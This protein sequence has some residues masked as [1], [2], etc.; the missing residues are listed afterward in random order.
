MKKFIYSKYTKFIAAVLLVVSITLCVLSG[1]NG[2]IDCS[3][4]KEFIYNFESDFKE[5]QHFSNL[6][7]ATEEAV[8]YPCYNYDWNEFVGNEIAEQDFEIIVQ[9]VEKQLNNLYC[10]D[11]I[12][13]YVKLNDTVF[14]NCGATSENDIVTARIYRLTR[15]NADGVTEVESSLRHDQIIRGFPIQ[16]SITSMVICTSIK[17]A[18]VDECKVIWYRQSAMINKIF[19]SVLI[20]AVVAILLFIYLI[21]VCGKTKDG[22]L[23]SVWIDNIWSEIHLAFIVGIGG[24]SVAGCVILIDNLFRGYFSYNFMKIVI[25]SLVAIVSAI[26]LTSL[27]SVVRKIKSKRFI[28]TSIN[29]RL[30]KRFFKM[31]FNFVK[32]ST[33]TSFIIV[34][35]LLI[36]T[37]LIGVLA[38]GT[39][40]SPIWFIV[41][42]LLFGLASFAVAYRTKDIEEIKKG[43]REVRKGNLSY[44][45]PEVKSSDMKELAGNIND[46]A[47]G[48]DE[49]VSAKLKA[50]RLKTELIT[51]VSHDLKTPITS[52]ISYTELLAKIE[53][54]PEEARDYVSVISKKSER[55]KNLTQD[56]FDISKVQSGNEDV[57]SEKLDVSLL[58]NQALGEN[59]NEIQK[60]GLPFCIDT[61]KELYISADGRK[62]SRV[63]S[64]LINNILKYAMKNTRVFVTAFEKDENVVMEFKNIAAYPMDFTADEIVGRFVRGDESRTADGNGL[65]LAIAK[66]YTEICGGNFEVVID[67]DMFK[68]L[69]KFRKNS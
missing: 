18:Y 25:V 7:A 61:P 19:A 3:N 12:N 21:C 67:G 66:S 20:C 49:S 63:V 45:I 31:I 8:F 11:K 16:E 2:V 10:A 54:L 15:Q 14:T 28:Q 38:V 53:E 44:K 1:V 35:M 37:A 13:Y 55:L 4:E 48:L 29:Y 47:K 34:A 6:F 30:A 22:E 58:I 64:N 32:L 5:M 65:G 69:L 60:S 56:L 57:V 59:D 42:V 23:V 27:L 33:K 17:E 68:V 41:G 40:E 24:S 62:M 43:V 50:E 26:V 39:F 52:I 36:Y 46:I 9:K 51:N